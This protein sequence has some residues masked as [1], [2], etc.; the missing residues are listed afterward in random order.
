MKPSVII[1]SL[2]FG[3]GTFVALCGAA[4]GQVA[5]GGGVARSPGAGAGGGGIGGINQP[6]IVYVT[7]P[8]PKVY[9][10]VIARNFFAL[11]GLNLTPG[12]VRNQAQQ[13]FPAGPGF[14]RRPFSPRVPQMLPRLSPYLAR[15]AGIGAQR[16][17]R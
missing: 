14:A 6:G 8:A 7:I 13:A 1:R 2:A 17:P 15:N 12:P 16:L 4:H 3:L 5:A 9:P 10:S 11:N